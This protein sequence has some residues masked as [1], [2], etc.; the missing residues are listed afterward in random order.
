[1]LEYTQ[2]VRFAVDLMRSFPGADGVYA[3]LEARDFRQ[4][5]NLPINQFLVLPSAIDVL[6]E[7]I[8]LLLTAPA[9]DALMSSTLEQNMA[10][11][12]NASDAF[13][14]DNS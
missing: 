14:P 7:V 6:K 12:E 8:D 3:Q 9:A 2:Q 4:H 1:M 13:E 5:P 10:L 11:S